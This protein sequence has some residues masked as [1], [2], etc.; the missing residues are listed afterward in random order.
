MIHKIF[1]IS[2]AR[3]KMAINIE[4]KYGKR[5]DKM[6]L[7]STICRHLLAVHDAK[8]KCSKMF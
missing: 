6:Q 3:W 4:L 7:F 5:E 1:D 8:N 2:D